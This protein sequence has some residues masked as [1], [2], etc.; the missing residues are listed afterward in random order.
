MNSSDTIY[1]PATAPGISGVAIIRVSGPKAGDCL[2]RLAGE[3]PQPRLASLAELRDPENQNLIDQA[4]L[5]WFPAPHSFTGEDVAEFHVHGGRAVIHSTL[6]A[7]SKIPNCRMAEAGEFTRRA[8]L[9]N[10]LD[11]TQVEGL[12]DLIQAQTELQAKQALRQLSGELGNLYETWRG[13]LIQA[14]AYVEASIDFVEEDLDPAIIKQV[15]SKVKNLHCRI[16]THLADQHRGEILRDG[17][18]AAILGPPNAGKS[19]L[20]NALARREAAIVSHIAGTTRDVIEVNLDLGGYPVTLAD[21]AGMRDSVDEI[22]SEG[23]KRSLKAAK[24]ADLKI[25]VIEAGTAPDQTIKNLIDGNSIL[26]EN[27]IDLARPLSKES[28]SL[29]MKTGE[30]LDEL[31][32]ILQQ[33]AS[34]L[35]ELGINPSLTRAR[36][37]DSLQKCLKALGDFSLAKPLELAAED[38]RYATAEIGRITGRVDVEDLLDVIFKDFCIGK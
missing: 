12:A 23:I 30:G 35:M 18:Y 11:L 29:S 9:N 34:A 26:V 13:E 5:L 36:H 32:K 7:L 31:L 38:L 4:L 16:K 17:L 24:A 25:I 10:K 37:R 27:K 14:L 28:L 22:E 6:A 3:I 19:S 15:E 21:T 1:A 2:R 8:F 20:L 33:K